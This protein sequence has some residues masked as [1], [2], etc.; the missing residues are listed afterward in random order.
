MG[1]QAL[2]VLPVLQVQQVQALLELLVLPAHLVRLGLLVRL[3]QGQPAQLVHQVQVVLPDH[4]VH[5]ELQV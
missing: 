4:P 2:Q 1:H 3:V 5:Q